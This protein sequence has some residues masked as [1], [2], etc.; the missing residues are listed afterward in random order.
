M[1]MKTNNVIS[2]VLFSNKVIY[3]D[4]MKTQKTFY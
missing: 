4:T 2:G 1:C 3:G